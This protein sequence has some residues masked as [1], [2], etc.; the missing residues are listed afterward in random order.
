MPND[1]PAFELGD[2]FEIEGVRW[3]VTGWNQVT[4]EASRMPDGETSQGLGRTWFAEDQES[5]LLPI[6]G[7]QRHQ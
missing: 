7:W 2:V 1:E 6:E 4:F 5:M 3:M